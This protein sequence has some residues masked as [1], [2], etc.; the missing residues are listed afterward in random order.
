MNARV[1]V[2]GGAGY[3][4]S[5]MAKL[6]SRSG[7]EVRVFDN[8]TTGHADVASRHDF[9]QGDMRIEADL[10]RAFSGKHFDAV[11]H[12]AANAYVGE[13]V[14]DPGKYYANNVVGTLRVLEAMRRSGIRNLIFSSSCTVYGTPESLPISEMQRLDPVNPYGM[15]KYAA[16]RMIQDFACAYGIRAVSLRYFNAAGC[17]PE[18][19]LGERHEPETHLVPLVLLEALRVARG[20]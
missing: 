5:H 15:T 19:E 7:C 8:L 11:M 6:L 20:G 16:E 14:I 9:V 3:I 10:D 12:F 13:S 18:G 4:G 1:L 17:D 2:L